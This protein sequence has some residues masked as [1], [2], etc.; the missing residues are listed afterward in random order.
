MKSQ[1]IVNTASHPA[2]RGSWVKIKEAD[3]EDPEFFRTQ[4]DP[5]NPEITVVQM[6]TK[7]YQILG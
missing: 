3:L 6:R 4:K 2:E 7:T 1:P 5:E